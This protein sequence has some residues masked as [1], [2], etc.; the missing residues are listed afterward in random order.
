MSSLNF[1]PRKILL[2]TSAIF[3]IYAGLSLFSGQPAPA[4][5]LD[6]KVRLLFPIEKGNEL[7]LLSGM[8]YGPK[9]V[10]YDNRSF[11]FVSEFKD[12]TVAYRLGKYLQKKTKLPFEISYDAGHPQSS[13]NWLKSFNKSS[14]IK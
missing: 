10:V 13:Q 3:L 6:L 11:V 8:I 7:D 5:P 4:G 14:G 12:A 2:K 9:I 1:S